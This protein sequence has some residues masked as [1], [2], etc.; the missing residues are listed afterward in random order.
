MSSGR[1][2]IVVVE[3]DAQNAQTL[4]DIVGSMDMDCVVVGRLDEL[5]ALLDAGTAPCGV[6]QDMQVPYAPG[7]RPH[8]K[9]GESCIADVRARWQGRLAVAIVVVTGYRDDPDFVWA[10]SELDADGFCSKSNIR[11]LPDKLRAALRK[12]G[13]EDHAACARCGEESQ[14]GGRPLEESVRLYSH[15]HPRGRVLAADEA[16]AIQE[17]RADYDLFLDYVTPARQGYVAGRR[18]HRLGFKETYLSETSA[19]I[20]SELVEAGR[21]LRANAIPRLRNG[22]HE[23]AVRLVQKARQ[24][25]DVRAMIN[26]KESRTEWRAIRSVGTKGELG[27]V[28]DPRPGTRYA[29]LVRG[30]GKRGA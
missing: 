1:H 22:G 25:V 19:A 20:L 12:R 17:R 2:L 16:R 5:R 28:F 7:A 26:G 11:A 29:V 3:D 8:E 10:M 27:F 13:R 21:A 18:D 4:R 23:S 15:E 6:L 14:V 30:D 24:A 9:A